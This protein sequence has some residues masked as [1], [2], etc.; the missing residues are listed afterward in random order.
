MS[1]HLFTI[2]VAVVIGLSLLLYLFTYQVRSNE[3]AIVLRFGKPVKLP[4][5]GIHLR[6]PWP[7][8]EV[9]RFDNRLHVEEGRF[10]ETLTRD[11]YNVIAS[12]CIGWRIA[13]EGMD[14]FNKNFGGGAEPIADGWSKLESIVRDRVHVAMGRH[15]LTDFVTVRED[16]RSYD[17]P[18]YDKL[19]SEIVETTRKN[20]LDT[21]GID[22]VL[23]KV[24]RL[25]L[26]KSVTQKVYARMKE[27]RERES[28]DIREKG[29]A[30]AKVIREEARSNKNQI[31]ARANAAAERIRGAGDA[32]AAQYYEVLKANPELAIYLRK[33]RALR[34]VTRT[35]TT[36]IVD[37]TT[38]PFDL[39]SSGTPTLEEEK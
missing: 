20:A 34:E 32:E 4:E 14:Q 12:V 15:D 16:S 11:Q 25:E 6:W 35:G 10:E 18:G 3:V 8:D 37:T 5:A 21:Y 19:E 2:F 30:R 28:T 38:P 7:I 13:P 29:T 36:V 23:L 33:I 9:R 17:H 26:P 27:D 31:I 1:R 24:K 22:V 39:F